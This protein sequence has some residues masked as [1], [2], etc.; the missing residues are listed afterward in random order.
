MYPSTQIMIGKFY[1]RGILIELKC[2]QRLFARNFAFRFRISFEQDEVW[3]EEREEREALQ[4]LVKH[5]PDH[6]RR[7]L[8]VDFLV[9]NVKLALQVQHFI[10]P[11]SCH[12]N[13]C[14][15][16]SPDTF[17]VLLQTAIPPRSHFTHANPVH[18][19]PRIRHGGLRSGRGRC[20]GPSSSTMC[21]PTHR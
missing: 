19:L 8:P 13:D 1:D 15:S 20:H 18:S 10:L 7:S 5:M 17:S 4:F 2:E 11:S 21:C 3:S 9:S 14:T 12:L 16:R 6:D